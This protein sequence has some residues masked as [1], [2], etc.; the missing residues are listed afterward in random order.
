MKS[1][2]EISEDSVKDLECV[3][4]LLWH[5][6]AVGYQFTVAK[7]HLFHKLV[8]SRCSWDVVSHCLV[9]PRRLLLGF[10]DR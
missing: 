5:K 4:V 8:V 6:S 2:L 9:V 3:A 1:R 10:Y 7:I